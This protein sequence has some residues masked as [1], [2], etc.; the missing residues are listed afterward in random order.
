MG[1]VLLDDELVER[2]REIRSRWLIDNPDLKVTYS[3]IVKKALE[4]LGEV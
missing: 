1:M 2:M 3:Y 4:A